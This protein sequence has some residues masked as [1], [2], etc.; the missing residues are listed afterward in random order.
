MDFS[1][2]FNQPG[3]E[4]KLLHSVALAIQQNYEKYRGLFC[5]LKLQ[6]VAPGQTQIIWAKT[7]IDQND[8]ESHVFGGPYCQSRPLP[9]MV[10]GLWGSTN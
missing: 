7:F 10:Q 4:L 2:L 6:R 1:H 8:L 5:W 9:L 3:D